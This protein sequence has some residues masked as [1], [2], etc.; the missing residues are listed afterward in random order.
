MYQGVEMVRRSEL[1]NILYNYGYTV[2]ITD[3]EAL[4]Q[5]YPYYVHNGYIG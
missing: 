4:H 5:N 3:P 2:G 1:F